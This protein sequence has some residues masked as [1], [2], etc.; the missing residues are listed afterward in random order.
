MHRASWPEA[1]PLTSYRRLSVG[2]SY[3]TGEQT[4]PDS[5]GFWPVQKPLY[6]SAQV[7]LW[8]I[9][10]QKEVG[11]AKSQGK[12]SR[13]SESYHGSTVNYQRQ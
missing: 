11:S 2:S 3:S 4:K 5:V 10:V 12:P 1:R 13:A 9:L 7:M 8:L 6:D